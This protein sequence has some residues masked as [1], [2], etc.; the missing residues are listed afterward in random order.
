MIYDTAGNK[1][2][3]PIS[4]TCCQQD[5]AGNHE[6]NCPNNPNKIKTMKDNPKQKV[7]N[8]AQ[9]DWEET[10]QGFKTSMFCVLRAVKSENVIKDHKSRVNKLFDLIPCLLNETREKEKEKAIS[11]VQSFEVPESVKVMPESQKVKK[12][13]QNL[14]VRLI[15]EKLK[16]L[17]VIQEERLPM[18]LD[19]IWV[20]RHK[21]CVVH[22][23]IF[24]K[25]LNI[26][27]ITSHEEGKGH[28]SETIEELIKWCKERELKLVSSLPI[29][30]AWAHLCKKY[31]LKVYGLY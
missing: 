29:S 18:W 30:E 14:I 2:Y 26:Q 25:E 9:L 12:E 21:S 24:D 4:C 22:L 7:E 3:E 8:T 6:W 10:L 11:I 20:A 23:A 5:T 28:A 27:F 13:W 17:T 31:K 1:I 15:V 19:P 16:S